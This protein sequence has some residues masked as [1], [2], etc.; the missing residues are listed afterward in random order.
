MVVD[1]AILVSSAP[2]KLFAPKRINFPDDLELT[3]QDLEI[4]SRILNAAM[5]ALRQDG[6]DDLAARIP[7]PG[8]T[9]VTMR[10]GIHDWWADVH[11]DGKMVCAIDM[12]ALGVHDIDGELVAL[13][14]PLIGGWVL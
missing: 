3:L 6:R 7:T 13:D 1:R 10:R 14:D 4:V 5:R 12:R 2:N 8:A 9:R 11:V